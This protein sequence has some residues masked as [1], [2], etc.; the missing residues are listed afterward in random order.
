[1]KKTA[2]ALVALF[3]IN[4]IAST[5][6]LTISGTVSSQCAFSSAQNGTFGFDVQNPNILD[7]TI[8]GGT[9]ASVVI[10]YN[11]LPTISVGQITQFSSVPQG[12]ADTVNFTNT[13][14][15]SNAGPISYSN[16]VATFTQTS[17]TSDNLTLRLQAANASAPFPIGNY[18]A[19]TIV[20][21]T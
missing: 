4:A 8:T 5:Q 7:T 3:S 20:T 21:C 10:N 12:F 15:S 14:I 17:G 2:F 13:F 9:N 16:G 19:T 1:M 11:G 6:N 18:T